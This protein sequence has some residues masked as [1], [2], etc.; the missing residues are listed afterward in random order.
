M[1]REYDVTVRAEIEALRLH[2]RDH[3]GSWKPPGARRDSPTQVLEISD[4]SVEYF[5]SNF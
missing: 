2:T 1:R 3:Q 4:G 5:I